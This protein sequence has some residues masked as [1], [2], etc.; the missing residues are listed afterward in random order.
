MIRFAEQSFRV[1]CEHRG[2]INDCLRKDGI[3]LTPEV[4]RNFAH[5]I[6]VSVNTFLRQRPDSKITYREAH[7]ELRDLWLLS[8]ENDP[9][10]GQIRAHVANLSKMSI[11]YLNTRAS[12][13]IP[14]SADEGF[15]SWAK[16]ADAKRLVEAI[17]VTCADGA[18]RI[19]RSRGGGKRSG[20]RIEPLVFGHARGGSPGYVEGGRP[21]H[22][23]QDDL[24]MHLA[25]D[26]TIA[27][28]S[29]PLPG[30]SDHRGFGD[31]VHCVFQW[32]HKPAADQ[33]LRRYWEA[34]KVHRSHSA[35]KGSLSSA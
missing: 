19:S 16:S 29:K 1:G 23:R 21:R 20:E 14:E 11:E 2:R 25:I 5:N 33:A 32:L 31:L 27:T 13:V 4:E 17:R 8:I 34:V 10:V 26:W 35:G 6:C 22:Y 9:P 15:L 18:K 3:R 7:A 12:Q 30:R 28:G 24:V